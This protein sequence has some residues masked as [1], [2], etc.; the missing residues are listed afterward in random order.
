MDPGAISFEVK[1]QR[2]MHYSDKELHL[3]YIKFNITIVF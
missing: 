1:R 2:K 3:G